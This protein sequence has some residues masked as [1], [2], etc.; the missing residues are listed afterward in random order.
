M[1]LALD[2]QGEPPGMASAWAARSRCCSAVVIVVASVFFDGTV[3]P[4]VAIMAVCA[5]GA[6]ALA[7]VTLRRPPS[8]PGRRPR[9]SAR[10]AE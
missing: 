9:E 2:E 7:L 5:G 6:F 1:V 3:L 10:P 4:M 8:V